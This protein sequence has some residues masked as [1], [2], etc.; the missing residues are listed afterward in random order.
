[1]L[2]PRHH[3]DREHGQIIVLAA[4]AFVVVLGFAALVI[5]LGFL[6]N[7]RSRLTNALDAASLAGAAYMVSSGKYVPVDNTNL[8][9]D[10]AVINA[11][12][13]ANFPGLRTS[14]NP[15][16]I[17]YS[18]LIGV[19][20]D[21]T[22]PTYNQAYVARDVG[23]TGVVCDP[24]N[25]VGAASA[26]A[27]LASSFTGAGLI[28]SSAC[29]P[30]LGDKCDAVSITGS[31]TRQYL[32]APA[33]GAL[34]RGAA[35]S[36]GSTGSVV[37][38]ACS[39]PCGA[40]PVMPVDLVIVLDRTLSMS[41]ASITTLQDAAE[42]V[43]SVY[44]PSKQRVALAM[45]G[46]S[47][48]TP[49]T[50]APA[51]SGS[52]SPQ[53]YG[54]GD[55]NNWTPYTTV[56][57]AAT[58]TQT[59][60]DVNAATG[61]AFPST[62]SVAS[63]FYIDVD[64][65]VS[66]ST[67]NSEH[68]KVTGVTANG[69]GFTWTVVRASGS[70]GSVATTASIHKVGDAVYQLFSDASHGNMPSGWVPSATTVG[71]WVPVGLSGTDT[72]SVRALPNP[73]GTAGAYSSGGT[74]STTSDIYKAIEC[75]TSFSDGTDLSTPIKM[76]QWYLDQYGRQGVTQGIILETDGHPQYGFGG[77]TAQ[78]QGQA[79][80]SL[81][82]TCQAA[83]DA[84]A[85]AKADKTNSPDGIQIFTIGYG[86]ISSPCPT[87][88]TTLSANS[89]TYNYYE[90]TDNQGVNWS[91]KPA[92]TLLSTM[93]TDAAHNVNNATAAQLKLIFKQFAIMLAASGTHLVN[94]CP[95][96]IVTGISTPSWSAGQTV[97]IYG[98]N[99]SGAT[100]VRVA[101]ATPTSFTITSDSAISAKMASNG[102]GSSASVT[103]PCGSTN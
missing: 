17:T 37:S 19:D 35:S 53:A 25:A 86:V 46:P 43:L 30:D 42:V 16:T 64:T 76:A 55:N 80:T 3:R 15:P 69:S 48:I 73:S 83:A 31:V 63:P 81:A 67:Y 13:D 12:L 94:L 61:L 1:M 38:S 66:G 23:S 90:G 68:M 40:P 8:A 74:V 24:H 14:A 21:P 85:A 36:S 11:T 97:T 99:F 29:R 49:S 100:S 20:M 78:Y 27:V 33:L 84:A 88:T 10:T 93:A 4:I 102:T 56:K 79:D 9:A 87:T 59:S 7:D 45:V 5:D 101:G 77:S 2:H 47:V 62:A 65:Q 91:G 89:E 22:S 57:T 72:N 71:M 32:F 82:F 44:D 41:S 34:G 96:P 103:T 18:C 52:C 6:R 26:S 70:A 75:T 50:G 54:Y 95:A 39:G 60:L 51:L 58:A 98:A 92:T 28:R